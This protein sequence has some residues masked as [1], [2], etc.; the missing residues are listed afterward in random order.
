MVEINGQPERLDLDDVQARAARELGVPLVLSTDAHG[1]DD[2][3]HMRLA[4]N[5]ARRAWASAAEVANTVPW[6]TLR[7]RLRRRRSPGGRPR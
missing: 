3:A 4:V 2:L 7:G 5:Q 1:C 6:E